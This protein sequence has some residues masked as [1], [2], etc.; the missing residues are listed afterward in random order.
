IK[1]E[2]SPLI[3]AFHGGG[4]VSGDRSQILYIFAPIIKELRENGYAIATVQYSYAQDRPFPAQLQDCENAIKYLCENAEYYNIDINSIGVLGYSAGAQL[5]MLSSYA[6]AENIKY[7]VSFAGPSKLYGEE[8]YEYSGGIRYVLEWLFDGPYEKNEAAYMAG[9]PYFYLD[10]IDENA[11]KAPLLLVHDERDDV[12]PFSQSQL[13]YEKAIETGI[14]CELIKLSG[15]YH[16][17]DFNFYG[18][19][20]EAEAVLDFIYK[21]SG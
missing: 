19:E 4:W 21:Y 18:L 1:Y 9:S 16:Q 8:L 10:H 5:A 14:S 15:V 7:C 6:T 13:M 2:N 11:N 12:V 3:V 20:N 17:I